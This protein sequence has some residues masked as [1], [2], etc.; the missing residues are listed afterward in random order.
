VPSEE[1]STCLA[2]FP[3]EEARHILPRFHRGEA[4]FF[5][6]EGGYIVQH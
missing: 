1:V 5:R 2:A 6:G 3:P 4:I